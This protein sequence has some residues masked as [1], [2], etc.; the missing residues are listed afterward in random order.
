M[1]QRL[2]TEYVKACLQ[3]TAQEMAKFVRFMGDQNVRM[4][5]RVLENG[6]H[7]LA[8]VDETGKEEIRLIFERHDDLF[9]CVLSCRLVHPKLT[10]AMRKA[11]SQFRG[12]AV[13]NRIYP[14][15]TM[16]Y[17]YKKGAV[18]R[19]VELSGGESRT[20]FE[21]KDTLG[22]LE[23]TFNNRQVE[24]EIE[25]IQCAVNELLDLRNQSKHAAEIRNIDER[26]K[27]CTRQ[28]F[29]FEAH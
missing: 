22:M 14:N 18:H 23:R 1:A 13:V 9:V 21:L 3:L 28:L 16:V 20:V 27:Q 12:D 24:F 29:V 7:E 10:N 11:V 4:Q 5:V 17:H 15:Y 26:L 6:N 19:I 25:R 8:L 2:A